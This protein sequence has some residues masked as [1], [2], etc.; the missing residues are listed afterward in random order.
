M[1]NR[2][3]IELDIK[4]IVSCETVLSSNEI[5]IKLSGV[6]EDVLISEVLDNVEIEKLLMQI[7]PLSLENELKRKKEEYEN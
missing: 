2:V 7:D 3:E 1:T 5:T 4:N 6:D